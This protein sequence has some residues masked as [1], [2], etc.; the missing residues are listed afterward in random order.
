MD[1]N[2]HNSSLNINNRKTEYNRIQVENMRILD[3]IVT[4]KG[5]L[6]KK[7]HDDHAK[8][9]RKLLNRLS[10]MDSLPLSFKPKP[11]PSASKKSSV[12]LPQA[13]SK[14]KLASLTEGTG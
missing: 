1:I 14:L 4:R 10:N 12:D 3:R 11:L 5:N 7:S 13:K 6:S 8:K 2:K 9:H